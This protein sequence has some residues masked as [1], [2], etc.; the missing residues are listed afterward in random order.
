M[1]LLL[2]LEKINQQ[3]ITLGIDSLIVPVILQKKTIYVGINLGFHIIT[4]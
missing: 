1:C 4:I 2:I 3:N